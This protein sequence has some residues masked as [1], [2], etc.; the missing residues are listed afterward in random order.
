MDENKEIIVSSSLKSVADNKSITLSSKDKNYIKELIIRHGIVSAKTKEEIIEKMS[1]TLKISL[2][3]ALHLYKLAEKA[4]LERTIKLSPELIKEKL[5]LEAEHLKSRIMEDSMEDITVQ[6]REVTR[7]NEH[8]AKI[9]KIDAV[10]PLVNV[11][12]ITSLDER[13]LINN[14]NISVLLSEDKEKEN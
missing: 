1:E 13:T 10:P 7:I 11:N 8:L 12:F 4:Y 9:N 2:E 14:P 3:D 6:A 5:N